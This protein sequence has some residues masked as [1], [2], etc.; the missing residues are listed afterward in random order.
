MRQ[1]A[2][3]FLQKFHSYFVFP[4][5]TEI[6]ARHV[7]ELLPK[8]AFVLDVGCGNGAMDKKILDLRH[9][10]KI[11]GIDVLKRERTDRHVTI[12]NGRNLPFPDKNFDC[13]LFI[14]TLHHTLN[15]KELMNEAVRVSA[16]NIII[17]DHNLQNK[18]SFYILKYMDWVGN[19]PYD[20]NLPFNYLRASEWNK[21]FQNLNLK[22]DKEIIRLN[23]YPFPFNL[24][25]ERNYHFLV[26]LNI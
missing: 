16:K 12:F 3:L 18:I 6:I 11:I 5:R 2:E 25:F 20:V 15:H 10:I 26:K 9:D 13:V 1:R 21:I 23:L 24:L 7:A 8:N 22:K 14:D 4:R 17:K 19:K